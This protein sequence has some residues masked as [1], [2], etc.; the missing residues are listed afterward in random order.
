[1][2]NPDLDIVLDSIIASLNTSID[3]KGYASLVVCGGRSPLPLYKKLSKIDIDWKKISIYLGDDRLVTNDHV[4]SN[5]KLIKDYLLVNNASSAKFIS[6]LKPKLS[7]NEIKFPFDIVLLGL[8]ADGHFASL[9]PG[10]NIDLN[11]KP[12]LVVSDKPEG[13]PSYH[14]VS[15][16]ISMLLNT[17]IMPTT[18]PKSPNK[19]LILAIVLSMDKF[20]S[21]RILISEA[22]SSAFTSTNSLGYDLY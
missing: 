21:K 4:D 14:R 17:L 20:R 11:D 13:T 7:I 15:M 6:L 12:D 19:G 5:E 3:V 18:V 9:F 10:S 2:K 8:G 22:F 1:L 16:N